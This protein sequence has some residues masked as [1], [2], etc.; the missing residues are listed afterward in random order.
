MKCM[1]FLWWSCLSLSAHSSPGVVMRVTQK[2]LDYIRS[3]GIEVFRHILL[4]DCLPDI[5]GS[6]RAFGK[7]EYAISKITVEEFNIFH[8]TAIP[9][10]PSD[11]DVTMKDAMTNVHGEWKVQHWLINDQGTF[12]LI[13]SEVSLAAT[14]AT[15]KDS[16]GCPSAILSACHSEITKAKLHLSGGAS[17]F[18]NLFTFLLEKPIKDKLNQMLCPRV[19]K[20]ITILQKELATFQVTANLEGN[21]SIDYSLISPPRVQKYCIDLDLKGTIQ[22]SGASDEQD[23]NRAPLTLP[24]T[25]SAMVLV[26]LSE[27]FFNDLG[28][29]YFTADTL[30]LTLNQQEFPHSY[31][32]RT[33]DYGSIIPEMKD[34]YPISEAMM[35][36][37]RATKPPVIHLTSQ[38][39][40][41]ME[42][43][44]EAFV[45]LPN[46]T[47]K[48][49]Y[50]LDVKAMLIATSLQVVNLKLVVS[51]A[52]DRFQ[53]SEFK[54][55]VGYVY[56]SDLEESLGNS[57]KESALLAINNGL[58]GGI[59][60][61][62]L[63]NITL[64]ET[65][66]QITPG[67]LL[68]LM[69]MYYI[70]WR[71]LLDILPGHPSSDDHKQ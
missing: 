29:F 23:T 27:Y 66:L 51:F 54:S 59:P 47:S 42:G 2:W 18:Y 9:L 14:L 65:T 30:K 10:P 5:I 48:Q 57:L 64:Q 8:Y 4:Y 38:L 41:E 7:V 3:E 55:E 11:I 37:L 13:L 62:T 53:F 52:L 1:W 63:A 44:M 67:Y 60:M 33:G 26:G 25:S 22:H 40:M 50:S 35:I 45:V 70:P 16:S 46:L 56:V 20:V 32:L 34:H 43:H 6:T 49:I 31:W 36:T 19:N 28:K 58:R 17:W 21:G 71:K 68:A 15:L 61:P 12:N 69:D 39:A 24:D